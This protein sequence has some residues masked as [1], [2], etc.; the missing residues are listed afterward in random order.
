ME[1]KLVNPKGNQSLPFIG[2][3]DAE[4]ETSILWPLDVKNQLIGKDPDAGN[5]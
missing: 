1:I 5:D 2:R 3:T 4:V